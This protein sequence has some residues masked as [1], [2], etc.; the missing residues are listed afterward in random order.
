MKNRLPILARIGCI[1]LC[2]D[3][4]FVKGCQ[5]DNE[6]KALGIIA[7]ISSP[8]GS[9]SSFT[10]GYLSTD[11]AT[12]EETIFLLEE[13]LEKYNLT[14]SFKKLQIPMT[15]DAQLRH[16][17]HKLYS[18]HELEDFKSICTAHNLGNLGKA[19]LRHLIHYLVDSTEYQ[20]QLKTN[21]DI[22][23]KDLDNYFNNLEVH[24]NDR[25]HVGRL[26]VSNWNELTEAEK[27]S[28]KLSYLPIPKKFDI[29]FRNAY[30]RTKGLLSRWQE[31]ERIQSNPSHPMFS[32]TQDLNTGRDHFQFLNA[33]YDMR[34]HLVQLID[35]Y[36]SDSNFQSTETINSL[37]FGY[38]FALDL[39]NKNKFEVAVRMALLDGLTEQLCSHKAIQSVDGTWIWKKSSVPT[40]VGRMDKIGAF[41]FPG[42]QKLLLPRLFKR[43][44]EAKKVQRN[45]KSKFQL[46]DVEISKLV[47]NWRPQ[48]ISYIKEKDQFMNR[49][50]YENSTPIRSSSTINRNLFDDVS[51]DDDSQETSD[52]DSDSQ[53]SPIIRPNTLRDQST[54]FGPPD[55]SF[56][57][58]ADLGRVPQLSKAQIRENMINDELNRYANFSKTEFTAFCSSRGLTRSNRHQFEPVGSIAWEYW[59]MNKNEFPI[60]YNAIKPVL[61]A[62]TSSSA[63][64]RLFSRISAYTTKQ[65]NRFKSKNL[66]ALVQIA[67]ME[68]FQRITGEIF[69]ENAIKIQPDNEIQIEYSGQESDCDDSSEENDFDDLLNFDM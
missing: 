62:P 29:R 23:G 33:I 15:T 50:E 44:R 65:K 41:A 27:T 53:R 35:Y 52:S 59:R 5:G 54:S 37:I 4:K 18:K 68:D 40:R 20:D 31:L 6:N 25:D 30:Q 9:R 58:S 63:V 55:S 7:I 47:S 16:A 38:E 10:L 13:C 57:V 64:E 66:M 48:V 8:D 2:I 49:D 45:F 69:R 51:D 43:L 34:N 24:P 1:T 60:L 67:E 26:S 11:D 56:E 3:H 46:M 36:E 39:G 42:E 12:D 28:K 14:D 22:A 21:L 32:L 17:I 61:Q 19:C